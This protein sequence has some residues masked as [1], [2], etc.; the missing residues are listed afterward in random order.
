LNEVSL[1]SIVVPAY[2][3]AKSISLTLADI[4]AYFKQKPYN[5]EVIVAADGTDGTREVVREL[6][7]AEPRLTAIGHEQ[8]SGKGRGVRE[9]FARARGDLVGFVDA[10]NKTPIT[11]FDKFEREFARGCDVVIGSRA[12]AQSQVERPARWYRRLGSQ[13]FRLA[14]HAIVGLPGIA[15]TQCG[16]KFFTRDASRHIFARQRL[17]GYM[18][19]VEVL[20]LAAQAGFHVAEVPVR[21]RDDGD[22]R[23]NLVSGNVRNAL[24]LLRIRFGR[25]E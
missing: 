25:H 21:W 16:F 18:F 8:R 9:G 20:H 24:D 15:D 6:A 13:G 17:D 4:V 22:T 11:E 10:D 12:L 14:V 5:F 1:V 23:L 19:D 3:E 2:N 7:L